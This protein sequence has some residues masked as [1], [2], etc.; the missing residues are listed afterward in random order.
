MK[1]TY[2]TSDVCTCKNKV[3]EFDEHNF[4]NLLDSNNEF[5]YL[6]RIY[7]TSDVCTDKFS[8]V[9][10]LF[11]I[12]KW[13]FISYFMYL[14]FINFYAWLCIK[15]VWK[16]K[17]FTY[18]CITRKINEFNSLDSSFKAKLIDFKNCSH[19]TW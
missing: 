15:W 16:F 13:I 18:T 7:F 5:K 6:K 3:K 9:L 11:N 2:S 10:D 4:I 17:I 1:F 12:K 19:Q 8:K 14:I